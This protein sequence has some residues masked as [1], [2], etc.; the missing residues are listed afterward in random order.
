MPKYAVLAIAALGLV[1]PA[2]AER[3]W[4]VPFAQ[5]T[6]ALAQAARQIS[7]PDNPPVIFL[8]QDYRYTIHRD[9][10]IESTTRVLFRVMQQDAVEDWSSLEHDYQPWYQNKPQVRA[11]VIKADGTARWLDPATIADA[12]VRQFDATIYSDARVVRAPLPGVEAGSVVEYEIKVIDKVPLLEAGTAQRISVGNSSAI[13]RFHVVIEAEP[14]VT[15]KSATRGITDA[16]LTKTERGGTVRLECDLGPIT[17][18][19][20]TEFNLPFD[21]SNAPYIAFSTAASW[22]SVAQAY[23]GIVSA[24][25]NAA[26]PKPLVEPAEREGTV[27][28]VARRLAARLHRSVRY[29][30]VEFGE[31]AIVPATPSETL[32]R[33]YGDCKDK[34]ALLVAL[35]RAAGLQADVALLSSGFGPDVDSNLPGMGLFDH[36]I[37]YIAADP[38]IWIDATAAEVRVGRL[39]SADQG[40]L[41]LIANPTTT[42]LMKIPESRA[43]DNRE[44]HTFE[45]KLSE[46]GPG[47]VIETV[48]MDGGS[49]EASARAAYGGDEKNARQLI[50][51][52]AKR[53][54]GSKSV[55]KVEATRRDDLEHPFRMTLQAQKAGSMLTAADDA[56]A[57]IAPWLLFDNLPFEL[58]RTDESGDAAEP[59]PP[60]SHDF[61]LAEPSQTEYRYHVTPRPLFKTGTL[62]KSVE[63]KLGPATLT[64]TYQANSDNS[65]EIVY[66]LDTV[67]RRWTAAEVNAFRDAYKQH[68]KRTPEVFTFAPVTSEF[69]AIGQFEK[70]INLVRGSLAGRNDAM[71]RVRLS[72]LLLSAH[73][74]GPALREAQTATELD[75]KSSIAW[76]ALA[77]AY[78]HDTF[79]RRMQGNWSHSEAEKC[80]RKAIE[81]DPDDATALSDL[82]ILLEHNARGWRYAQDARVADAVALYRALAKKQQYPMVQQNL[83]IALLRLGDLDAA[84]EE[85]AKCAEPIKSLLLAIISAIQDGPA[86]AIVSVQSAFPDPT[87]RANQL[88]SIAATL[89][90][91]RRYDVG[92]VVMS[93][94]A[95]LSN[96]PELRTR[97]ELFGKVK[98]WEETVLPKQDPRWPVQRLILNGFR[99]DLQ[100]ASLKPLFSK[101][102]RFDDAEAG[103]A[104]MRNSTAAAKRQFAASGI[105]EEAVAD[106]TLSLM[107]FVNIGEE[108]RGYAISANGPGAS[109][110]PSTY[111]ILEDG[112]YRI[113]G[114]TAAGSELVGEIVLELLD[115][116]DLKGAQWWLDKVVADLSPASDGTG[117]PAVKGI[118]SGTTPELRG[119][120]AARVAAASLIAAGNGDAKAIGILEAARAKAANRLDKAQLDKAICEGLSKAKKWAELMIAAKALD[121]A[122]MFSEEA[123]RYSAKGA[124]GAKRWSELAAAAQKRLD[125]NPANLFALRN[126]ILAKVR[127][128]DSARARELLKKLTDAPMAT[129]DDHVFAAWASLMEGRVDSANLDS[130]KKQSAGIGPGA[131]YEYTLALVQASLKQP[132]DAQQSLL[133]GLNN[134]DYFSITPAGWLAYARICELYGFSGDAKAALKKAVE[135][136]TSEDEIGDFAHELA[137]RN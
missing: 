128:G 105:Q 58:V 78:Q 61:I 91:L 36:V 2:S 112:E 13:E 133:S 95:R 82:A 29:T 42:G 83:A 53:T 80:Y 75:P 108:G 132:D 117:T 100:L 66:R 99:D 84:K 97:A 124:A 135:S 48:Q 121:A 39:P 51:A 92:Q 102:T 74:G 115:K 90:Q 81:I 41:A 6:V 21:E 22:Q 130:L 118:W 93:A 45:I 24:R 76:Q 111:V 15:L 101:R 85:S 119:S 17:S 23:G 125:G 73:L 122:T 25:I 96:A 71:G 14:G 113:L 98:K 16:A 9:H 12:P 72:R 1:W 47:E 94:A 136:Q 63:A 30:G 8:L 38:A 3:V 87:Q 77:W 103:L 64:R 18:P 126:L 65:L 32:Q 123:F 109:A 10:R 59:I 31:A 110:F 62:P 129:S 104:K 37:V 116:Q 28:T 54:F 70:A 44:M 89:A 19:K 5:D 40:R 56:A 50:E 33:G 11:R 35:L 79:G 27:L 57:A 137:A 88:S 4:D 114:G 49:A 52:Y 67:R 20:H 55:G 26:N 86:R 69:V 60:R 120:G 134:E 43:E 131:T 106:F 107:S 34:A 7:R 46:F 68:N 127:A